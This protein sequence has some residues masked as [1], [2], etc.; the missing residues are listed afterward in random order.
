[1]ER[2]R[3]ELTKLHGTMVAHCRC[4]RASWPFGRSPGASLG[5]S[6]GLLGLCIHRNSHCGAWDCDLFVLFAFLAEYCL[7][8]SDRPPR[9]SADGRSK[10]GAPGATVE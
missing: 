7:T 4:S 6:S 5:P 8:K 9:T 1:M 10:R 2:R 3:N